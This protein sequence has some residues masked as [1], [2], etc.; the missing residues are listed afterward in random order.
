MYRVKLTC[1]D[2][3][4]AVILFNNRVRTKEL[5]EALRQYLPDSD[6][7]IW[8]IEADKDLIGCIQSHRVAAYKDSILK[9]TQLLRVQAIRYENRIAEVVQ[10]IM[11]SEH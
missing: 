3:E 4:P 5:L 6:K 7:T 1:E 8:I 9:S 2:I 10:R 11:S